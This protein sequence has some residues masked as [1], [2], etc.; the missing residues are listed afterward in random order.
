MRLRQRITT[1][2]TLFVLLLL[3]GNVS[4]RE[5]F[6]GENC[7]IDADTV[8]EGNV[9]VLCGELTV[10]GHI[11]GHLMGAARTA[12]INGRVDGSVYLV[13]GHVEVTG[14]IG[15]DVHFAG[16]AL[17]IREGAV[18]D[19]GGIVAASFS[20]TI[21]EG[22]TLTGSAIGA[23]YQ[24][25]VNGDI[26]Q[27]IVYWGSALEVRGQIGGDVDATVGDSLSDGASG[28]IETLLIPLDFFG[29]D[30]TLVDP[31]LRVLAP[32]QIDGRL[33]YFAPSPGVIRGTLAESPRFVSNAPAQLGEIGEDPQRGLGLFFGRVLREFAT[34]GLIGLLGLLLMPRQMQATLRPIQV[35]PISTFSVGMLSFILSF[36]IVL[37]IFLISLLTVL[38]LNILPLDEL[39]LVGAV[40][41]GLANIGGAGLFY[42][43][44]IFIA[45]VIVGLA[46]G[47]FLLRLT[48]RDDGSFRS[49]LL[50]LVIGL[51]LLTLGGALPILG[52]IVYAL[53]LFL[54]LGAILSVIRTRMQQLRG[55]EAPGEPGRYT[56]E[57]LAVSPPVFAS[58]PGDSETYTPSFMDD[59]TLEPPSRP[60]R[61]PGM[62]NLPPGF[63]FS[64]FN[65]DEN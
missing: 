38:L 54:G 13:G 48:R 5:I 16:V 33:T 32:A 42:F 22:T 27:E 36:P 50:S 19:I 10:D 21:E 15:R 64:W 31:G 61:G 7:T 59:W 34:L 23:S 17:D 41:L 44:A 49:L 43:T 11:E 4:A 45:R 57:M 24:L 62:T 53:S 46:L 25:I 55:S 2:L 18:F 30:L 37:I 52:F 1:G 63:D 65:D 29:F 8:I 40:V 14:E 51:F 26:E 60:S 35:H 20:T 3:T 39:V 28:Q 6:D 58:M 9:L 47:R 56:T 12:H